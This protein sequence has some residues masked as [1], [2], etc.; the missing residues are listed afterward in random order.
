[1]SANKEGHVN[2]A[3]YRPLPEDEYGLTPRQIHERSIAR[4]RVSLLR[5]DAEMTR[6]KAE[7]VVA[8]SVAELMRQ[9]DVDEEQAEGLKKL[10]ERHLERCALAEE[11]TGSDDRSRRVLRKQ[12]V[13]V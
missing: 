1:M 8:L 6:E 7:A 3:A 13:L 10:A 5:Y 4:R 9:L 2:L 12:D 11:E